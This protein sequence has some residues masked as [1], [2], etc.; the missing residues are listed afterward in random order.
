MTWWRIGKSTRERW[1]SEAAGSGSP[2]T[3]ATCRPRLEDE[4]L[5]K[6]LP[7]AEPGKQQRSAAAAAMRAVAGLW[8]RWRR[9]VRLG[10]WRS[11]FFFLEGLEPGGV[12]A[13]ALAMASVSVGSQ[14]DVSTL[15]A[16]RPPTSISLVQAGVLLQP[17]CYGP[18]LVMRPRI[19]I[20]LY[21][22]T[23]LK[24]IHPSQCFTKLNNIVYMKGAY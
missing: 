2:A 19:F 3:A 5:T 11:F 17:K 10:G 7:I 18:V 9:R 4:G 20:F 6:P 16:R 21:F 22:F 14:G 23:N 1:P 8:E 13:A 12:G 15:N 24:S